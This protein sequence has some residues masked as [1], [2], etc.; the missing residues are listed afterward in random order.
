MK[1]NIIV[2]TKGTDFYDWEYAKAKSNVQKI[3]FDELYETIISF[4][5]YEI[6]YIKR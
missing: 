2:G 6:I 1:S 4:G 3:I 5:D